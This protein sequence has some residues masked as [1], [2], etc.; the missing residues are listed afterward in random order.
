M[1]KF[2]G[3]RRR[4]LIGFGQQDVSVRNFQGFATL[5]K[6]E[7]RPL[8]EKEAEDHKDDTAKL[9]ALTIRLRGDKSL[10]FQYTFHQ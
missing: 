9:T 7:Y 10:L 6:A 4:A 5:F 1:S 2:R 8:T 3:W